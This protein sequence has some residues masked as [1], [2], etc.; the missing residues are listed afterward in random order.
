MKGD[1]VHAPARLLSQG[2]LLSPDHKH[3]IQ[4]KLSAFRG[5]ATSSREAPSGDSQLHN[6]VHERQ[7][8]DDGRRHAVRQRHREDEHHGAYLVACG[9]RNSLNM[10][11]A[12]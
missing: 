5:T 9:E 11:V 4:A 10:R 8:Q 7:R 3:D 6:E 2:L 12:P 1:T